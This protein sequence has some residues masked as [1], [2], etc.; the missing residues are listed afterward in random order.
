MFSRGFTATTCTGRKSGS[1]YLFCLPGTLV[2]LLI[3]YGFGFVYLYYSLLLK[4][5]PADFGGPFR[6]VFN[7]LHGHRQQDQER[8]KKRKG[9]F[10]I[11]Y[12][13]AFALV[14]SLIGYDLV[15]SMDPHWISTLFGAYTFVKAIYVGLGG[16]YHSGCRHAP[17][18]E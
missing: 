6:F 3:L 11:L 18:S 17:E 13:L 8:I 12:M 1:I 9:L 2:G 14:L 10:S 4:V 16:D 15:M 7:R 5:E